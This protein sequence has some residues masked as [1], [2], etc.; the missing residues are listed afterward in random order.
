MTLSLRL[1]VLRVLRA[2]VRR[3]RHPHAPTYRWCPFCLCAQPVTRAN[4][5][6]YYC[7][8]CCGACYEEKEGG[9]V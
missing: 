8:V 5:H 6:L 4:R 2:G 7:R 9:H 3:A 1:R